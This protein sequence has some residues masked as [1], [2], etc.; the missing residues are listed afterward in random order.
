[1]KNPLKIVVAGLTGGFITGQGELTVGLGSL[2][3]A[4]LSSSETHKRSKP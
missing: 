1:M 2:T 4:V 3:T